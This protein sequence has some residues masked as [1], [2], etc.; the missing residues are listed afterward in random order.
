MKKSF[1]ILGL[2]LIILL[3]TTIS[4]FASTYPPI[5][6]D[7]LSIS[8]EY[9]YY[10]VYQ[11]SR[12]GRTYVMIIA[13]DNLNVLKNTTFTYSKSDSKFTINA[14]ENI[15]YY[16]FRVNDTTGLW[17]RDTT[18]SLSTKT[19]DVSQYYHSFVESTKDIY[20]NNGSIFFQGPPATTLAAV[21]EEAQTVK[22]FQT[23]MSGI[24]P[25]LIAL[26]VGLV[27]F[28]KAWQLLLKELRKA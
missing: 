11:D 3:S 16:H 20:D 28:W 18:E 2:L 15:Q 26:V 12:N 24:I 25:Y 9:F 1:I 19:V 8:F 23:M 17:N 5:T 13:S 4:C 22:T 6:K 7:N 27:A 10:T 14:P 21:L